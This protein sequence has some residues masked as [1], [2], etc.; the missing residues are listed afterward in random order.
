[1]KILPLAL[2]F[3]DGKV[4]D[5]LTGAKMTAKSIAIVGVL[6]TVSA[7]FFLAALTILLASRVGILGACLIMGGLFGFLAAAIYFRYSRKRKQQVRQLEQA[8]RMTLAA[9][10]SSASGAG[11]VL[12]LEAFLRGFTKK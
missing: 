11:A 3:L 4:R 7:V 5:Q 10:A 9:S 6:G 2:A 8:E 12:L 1:M